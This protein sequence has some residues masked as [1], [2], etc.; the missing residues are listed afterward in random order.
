MTIH[1][2]HHQRKEIEMNTSLNP[3]NRA[4]IM[5]KL[6]EIIDYH[7]FES[8]SWPADTDA[9]R[10][11]FRMLNEMGLEE[12]V[13][14]ER[15]TTRYTTLGID[16]GAPLASYF[17]GA[18]EPMEVPDLLEMQGLIEAE[19]AQ[20]FY[21]S[22]EEDDDDSHVERVEKLVRRAHRRFCGVKKDLM[23]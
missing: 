15:N 21:T 16:C 13:Q 12:A 18:H 17:I 6:H 14:G 22:L 7:L 1:P 23:Q 8:T 20:A 9:V 19:E 3:A 2:Q 10:A 5:R 4:D 11:F